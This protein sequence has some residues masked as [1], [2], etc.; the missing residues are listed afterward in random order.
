MVAARELLLALGALVAYL[1]TAPKGR[2]WLS[3]VS[4]VLLGLGL[5]A[6]LAKII[7]PAGVAAEAGPHTHHLLQFFLVA[8]L[9]QS[10]LLI[11][12]VSVWERLT[13]PMPKIFLDV[14]R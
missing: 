6:L 9:L 1:A 4:I 14:L 13:S 7:F 12:A 8:S 11:G 5:L 2:R 10:L 3:W